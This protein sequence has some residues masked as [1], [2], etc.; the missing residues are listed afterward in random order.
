MR[1]GIVLGILLCLQVLMFWGCAQEVGDIDRTQPNKLSKKVFEGEWYMRQTVVEVPGTGQ[2]AFAG[3]EGDFE[4][5]R[6][7]LREDLLVARRVHEDVLGID[8]VNPPPLGVDN[9]GL[10][11]AG[12]A[13][14]S[15]QWMGAP[16]AAFPIVSHFDI[17][18]QYNA[19]T[20]EQSNVINENSSDRYWQDREYVRVNW[21]RN[22]ILSADMVVGFEYSA[23]TK[24]AP[25]T[26][27]YEDRED[28]LSP[29]YI[30]C[31]DAQGEFFDCDPENLRGDEEVAY[32]ELTNVYVVEPDWLDC[33]LTFGFP[34]YGGFCGAE[35]V[36]VRTSFVKVDP[37]DAATYE[38]RVYSDK[39]MEWFAYFRTERCAYDRLYGC[40]DQ[41]S[42]YLAN[43]HQIWETYFQDVDGDGKYTKDVD[44]YLPT[45][46][47]TPKPIVYYLTPEFP[48]DLIAPSLRIA[49][50]YSEEYLSVVRHHGHTNYQGRM[51]YICANSGSAE[52]QAWVMAGSDKTGLVDDA[53]VLWNE[54]TRGYRDGVCKREGKEKRLGD[55]RY[56]FFAWI[57]NPQQNGPLGYGPSSPDPLTGRIMA[58]NAHI[59][60]A[61]IDI[62]TQTQVDL[63]DLINGD[64]DP[65]AYGYGEN[66]RGYLEDAYTRFG[67]PKA[68]WGHLSE[69][70]SNLDVGRRE[71]VTQWDRDNFNRYSDKLEAA[72]LR[73]ENQD[74]VERMRIHPAHLI[75]HED[76][77]RNI[78]EKMRGTAIEAKMITP[79]IK[80]GLGG[81]N[82]HPDATPTQDVIAALTPRKTGILPPNG[83]R[84]VSLADAKG[85]D[86]YWERFHRFAD[87]NMYMAEFLDDHLLGLA[88]DMKD[89]FGHIQ[90][91]VERRLRIF[92]YIR[93]FVYEHVM[94]HEVGHTVGLRH[95][96][97]ASYD[98]MSYFPEYW[99]IRLEND[100]A[101]RAEGKE[102]RYVVGDTTETGPQTCTADA[103][104]G[105]SVLTGQRGVCVSGECM[106]GCPGVRGVLL[107]D[108]HCPSRGRIRADHEKRMSEY[109]YTSVMDYGA[110]ANHL[111]A[112]LGLYDKASLHYAYGDL[113]HVFKQGS[114]PT[115]FRVLVAGNSSDDLLTGI[116]RT[117]QPIRRWNDIEVV[118]RVNSQRNSACNSD[119]DCTDASFPI[120]HKP[121]AI[122]PGTCIDAAPHANSADILNYGMNYWHYSVLPLMFNAQGNGS[123]MAQ[124]YEREY[125]PLSE[126]DPK[127]PQR[128]RVPYRMCS[129]E[130]R[131][132]SPYCQVW[133]DGADMQEIMDTYIQGYEQYYFQN[134]YRRGR[135]GWGLWLWPHL[136]RLRNRYFS[137]MAALYQHWLIRA[138]QWNEVDWLWQRSPYAGSLAQVASEDG[139]RTLI[140]VLVAPHPGAYELEGDTFMN[141]SN[142]SDYEMGAPGQWLRMDPGEKAKWRFSRYAYDSGYYYFLRYEILSSFWDRWAAFTVLTNPEYNDLGVDSSSDIT[143]YMIPYYLLYSYELSKVFGGMMVEDF[144]QFSPVVN[145]EKYAELQAS[146]QSLRDALEY[147]DPLATP[148]QQAAYGNPARYAKLNPYPAS[149]YNRSY[150]DRFFAA[151]YG[152]A[153]FQVLY[154]QSFNHAS[155]IFIANDGG[156]GQG[157]ADSDGD[158]YWDI[159]EGTGDSNGNGIPDFLDPTSWPADIEQRRLN[160]ELYQDPF[161][162]KIY[163]AVNY[164]ERRSPLYSPGVRILRA[165]NELKARWNAGDPDVREW[166]VSGMREDIEN[167]ILCNQVFYEINS[168][169]WIV[170]QFD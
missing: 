167:I 129:D 27:W 58:G 146:G 8:S 95:N 90:D 117:S 4:R 37:V 108:H 76:R 150:N 36:K 20:G 67:I 154:D 52:E 88:L 123:S 157:F 34:L 53:A 131:G 151:V 143:G 122:I 65:L 3:W 145:L 72:M 156:F 153:F 170:D 101:L 19:S 166:D 6:F 124:M 84:R 23:Y 71:V 70:S 56:S 64:L 144:G 139:L 17:Q 142:E 118:N 47:R 25:E 30:E 99:Q 28:S 82:I 149:Y 133:D 168:P 109:G 60:G 137:P 15:G 5:V 44:I 1:R 93:A 24:G 114:E 160:M 43:R 115:K 54:L 111:A 41:T 147:R 13:S 78:W 75:R 164:T 162:H 80:A 73:R 42:L 9:P 138:S 48:V 61:D 135:A 97:E 127:N 29:I 112:G 46:A 169:A 159:L 2:V 26:Q 119:A 105:H 110:R 128:L 49:D 33:I 100:A 121:S 86:D 32:I 85:G 21:S 103:N 148:M 132:A 155:N 7:D 16:V 92:Y 31:R 161:N 141:R 102:M 18:R 68:G 107:G 50:E 62:W 130:M 79:E 22:Q 136:M 39:E 126:Y 140:S 40:R 35:V 163:A 66:I 152:L 134:S 120:C 116:E 98:S 10:Y 12:D 104:C 14:Y 11:G 113:L 81:G 59:Y 57:N 125:I 45:S 91:P 96:F 158:G 77:Y 89:M 106:T 87:R 94:I 63:I 74:F 165:A 38:P 69:V 51:F 55:V 83:M